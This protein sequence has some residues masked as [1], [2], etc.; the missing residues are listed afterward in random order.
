MGFT[1]SRRSSSTVSAL[2]TPEEEAADRLNHMT[3]EN[4]AS[5]VTH[6]SP[7][8]I[9]WANSIVETFLFY[10][11]PWGFKP[12]EIAEFFK[13][14]RAQSAKFW[15][16]NRNTKPMSGETRIAVEQELEAMRQDRAALAK[17]Q[18]AIAQL[19]PKQLSKAIGRG[20]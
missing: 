5:P 19:T 7:K 1:I 15:I 8:Q 6:G 4:M 16:D 11:H 13:T 17:S 14:Y 2:R 3:L 20:V 18:A 9:Q 12:E 10:A